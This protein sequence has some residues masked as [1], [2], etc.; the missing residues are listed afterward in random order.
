[1]NDNGNPV[2]PRKSVC[3]EPTHSRGLW[4]VAVPWLVVVLGIMLRYMMNDKLQTVGQQSLGFFFD[5][6]IFFESPGCFIFSI[7]ELSSAEFP[8]NMEFSHDLQEIQIHQEIRPVLL[9]SFNQ[10]HLKEGRI[11]LNTVSEQTQGCTSLKLRC[12]F[13]LCDSPVKVPQV[14]EVLFTNLR[15]P[16]QCHP[17]WNKAPIRPN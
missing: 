11:L 16:P 3:W 4:A 2:F 7:L 12:P 14:P 9:K 13:N 15:V 10:I 17:P 8:K 5:S 1:M 6:V